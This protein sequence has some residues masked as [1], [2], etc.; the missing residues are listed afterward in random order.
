LILSKTL[1]FSFLVFWGAPNL[2][3]LN[4]QEGRQR[5]PAVKI[6]ID[7]FVR[8]LADARS[9]VV[10]LLKQRLQGGADFFGAIMNPA[11]SPY[12]STIFPIVLST[13]VG[14][15]G[16]SMMKKSVK[17]GAAA[18]AAVGAIWAFMQGRGS[19]TALPNNVVLLEE[20]RENPKL[21]LVRRPTGHPKWVK[22]LA[23]GASGLGLYWAW[24]SYRWGQGK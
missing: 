7:N 5:P 20:Y 19:S 14:A 15:L 16:A 6:G 22:V 23:W 4:E 11:I 3:V 17:E 13:G 21:E 2:G 8:E 10:Y 24:R 9:T 12:A 1:S 18:G